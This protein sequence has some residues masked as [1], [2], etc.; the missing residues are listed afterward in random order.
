MKQEYTQKKAAEKWNSYYSKKSLVS[1][2]IEW[3]IELYFSRAFEKDFKRITKNLKGK[4]IEPGCG[5]GL[6]S[7]RLAKQG[8]EVTVLDITENALKTARSNFIKNKTNGEFVKAD[9]F[10]MPFESET[11]DIVWNQG[12]IEHFDDIKGVVKEMNRLVKK[13]GYLVIFVPAY[14]SPL[15]LIY[16]ILTILNLKKLWPFDDQIF[17]KKKQLFNVMKASGV[18]PVRVR[19]VKGSL[20]FSLVSYSRKN[21]G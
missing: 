15:H 1:R 20:F 21:G 4:I 8:Y 16:R 13:D 12:V 2:V 14:N 18:D 17:F 3:I 7:S 10:K 19:R 11:F 5:S 9:I 6:M